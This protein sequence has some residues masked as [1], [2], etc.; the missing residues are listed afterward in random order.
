MRSH[1]DRLD[2]FIA[3]AG[4]ELTKFE[5]SE[6]LERTLTI[7][8]ISTFLVAIAVLPKLQET[9]WKYD[10][11]TRL[12]LVGSIIHVFAPDRE[13][14][15][16]PDLDI[17]ANLSDPKTANMAE[18]Y[19]LSKLMVHQLFVELAKHL[20]ETSD[21]HRATVNLVNPGWCGTELSRHKQAAAFERISFSMIGW[22]G[23]KGSR[24][25]VHA[26]TAGSETHGAYL[27]Q[28]QVSPQGSYVRS[29]RGD[30]IGKTLWDDTMRRIQEIDPQVAKYVS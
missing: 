12:T 24:T 2:G 10:A 5:L 7:N 29:E 30:E 11:D 28:C 15:V 8:V 18:R 13:L 27:S 19:N 21:K 4:I 3:N 6:G 9:A 16:G 17:F 26:V 20:P 1:L 25:L 23:E 14:E 22:T